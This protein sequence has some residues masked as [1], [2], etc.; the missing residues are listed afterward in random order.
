MAYSIKWDLPAG[1][2]RL[3]EPTL[4]RDNGDRQEPSTN[5]E[6][7][8][9]APLGIGLE[10]KADESSG[11]RQGVWSAHHNGLCNMM[12]FVPDNSKA[13][14]IER[15]FDTLNVLIGAKTGLDLT[16]CYTLAGIP[17]TN[18]GELLTWNHSQSAEDAHMVDEDD[19]RLTV[20]R[21]YDVAPG[22]HLQAASDTVVPRVAVRCYSWTC[23][24]GLPYTFYG[25]KYVG[26]QGHGMVVRGDDDALRG[27][28]PRKRAGTTGKLYRR[29]LGSEEDGD[30]QLVG[31]GFGVD[32]HGHWK[33]SSEAILG[34]DEDR[35]I[36]EYALLQNGEYAS[37]GRFA[38][39]EFALLQDYLVDGSGELYVIEQMPNLI[40]IL[41]HR[42]GN[43]IE[44]IYTSDPGQYF[45]DGKSL[46]TFTNPYQLVEPENTEGSPSGYV[47]KSGSVY[48]YHLKG[49]NLQR[50]IS[51][52]L[53]SRWGGQTT[54]IT[55]ENIIKAN[56][57]WHEGRQ[58][59]VA[60]NGDG[61]MHIYT[62]NTHFDDETWTLGQNKFKIADGIS[63]E[64]MPSFYH[65][66]GKFWVHA[67][68]GEDV[69]CWTSGNFGRSWTEVD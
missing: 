68:V 64:N 47:S 12:M 32:E 37:M 52:P 61:A 17:I 13:A 48:A 38:T 41:V 27:P 63:I 60:V 54:V 6:G 59:C 22:M 11:Y 55:G 40:F 9:P 36:Y 45:R 53:A 2:Y 51:S 19:A 7:Y 20:L 39:R 57:V 8:R 24:R 56:A 30:Y 25:T 31:G 49:G 35:M 4:T 67:M 44:L 5:E 34:T 69:K 58:Y 43:G 15:V 1:E 65:A 62:S 18:S 10:L 14:V 66:H 3:N 29:P 23:V 16:S 50:L 28:W 33:S 42:P 26:G 46:G 21:A